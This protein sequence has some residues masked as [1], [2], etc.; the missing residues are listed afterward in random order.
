MPLTGV[1][2]PALFVGGVLASKAPADSATDMVWLHDYA[3]SNAAPHVVTAYCLVLAGLSLMTFLVT[4]W[5][6]IREASP[7]RLVSV[8]PA[9]AA[10]MAGALMSVG[11]VL[12]GVVS[13]HALRG[14]P[15]LI[16]LGNDAGFAMV[17]VGGMLAA[18]LS[19]VTLS[20]MARSAG[21]LGPRLAWSGVV[22][23]GLLP[24]SLLF[25]PIA[26]LLV[27]TVAVARSL[28][29]HPGETPVA[30]EIAHPAIA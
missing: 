2:F 21:V 24:A 23:A 27:W 16:R 20:L 17:S 8:V 28:L 30:R 11:G 1:A 14:Y 6:R 10:G 12:M 7:E 19:L 13:I 5:S 18:A 29:R 9:I 4:L 22:V 25:L 26:A 3:G 15:E